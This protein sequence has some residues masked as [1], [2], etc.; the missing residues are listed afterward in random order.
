MQYSLFLLPLF[1]S[2][3]ILLAL[4]IHELILRRTP[5]SVPFSFVMIL[6]S[7]WALFYALELGSIDLPTKILSMKL[8]LLCNALLPVGMLVFGFQYSG[9][10]DWL[11]PERISLFLIEPFLA[12]VLAFANSGALFRYNYHVD[13]LHATPALLYSNGV[14]YPI[15]LLYLYGL[16]VAAIFLIAGSARGRQPLFKRQV[17]A[18][19]AAIALPVI[20]DVLFQL[21]IISWRSVN[22]TPMVLTAS[23]ILAAFALFRYRLHDVIPIAAI[24]VM[25]TLEDLM[26]VLDG[27]G[28]LIDFNARAQKAIGFDPRTTVGQ[29]VDRLPAP[30]ASALSRFIAS[31]SARDR[32]DVPGP[33]GER[34]YDLAVSPIRDYL[35]R[36]QG[37]LFLLHDVTERRL[38]EDEVALSRERLQ[39]AFDSASDGLWDWEVSTGRTYWSTRYYTMLGY[40]PGEIESSFQSWKSLVHPE[41]LER[42]LAG[43]ESLLSGREDA[44]SLEFRMRSRDGGWRWVLSRGK[45]VKRTAAGA[46]ERI[47]GTH[48]DIT[49]RRIMEDRLRDSEE[50]FRSFVEQTAEAII[51]IDEE[52]GIIEFNPAAERLA[53][54]ERDKALGMRIWD[55][56]GL[57]LSGEKRTES[58]IQA[59]K[60]RYQSALQAGKADFLN[61]TLEAVLQMPNGTIKHIQQYLFPIRTLSGWRIGSVSRDITEAKKAEEALARSREQLQQAQKMEAV[62]RLAGGIAHDFNNILTVISG[63]CDLVF[64]RLPED[65]PLREDMREIIKASARASSLTS[66]LLAFSRKQVLQPRVISVNE[67]VSNMGNMLRRVIGE[68]IELATFLDPEAGNF[69]ADPGQIEQVIMNLAVNS[70]DAMPRGGKLTIE[71]SNRLLDQSYTR[72]HPEVK[73]G[74]Y[75]RL[76]VSDTGHGM[77]A[78]TMSR[79]FEPFFTTKEKGKGT[80]LGLPMAYGIIKQSEGYISCYSEPGKGTIFVLYFPRTSV[81]PGSEL[82][83]EHANSEV[84]GNET[85]LLVEDE[86]A[87]LGFTTTVLRKNGYT[88]VEAASGPEALAEISDRA[89]GVSLLITDVVMPRMSG[90]ELVRKV[91]ELCRQLKVLYIS[92]YAENAIV[93][94]GILDEGIDFI[95]KPFSSRKLLEKVREILDRS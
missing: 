8:R 85:I 66:Q 95:Q 76:T 26:L 14:L 48:V 35:G 64:D 31:S 79:I 4:A 54:L 32:L 29:S 34:T 82:A 89:C 75:V 45:V 78:D 93:H 52:G 88:V 28:R 50:K 1:F 63:Y 40:K 58:H 18:A 84:A 62:G 73:P 55:L 91:Q 5:A 68:D 27:K 80:G 20:S 92:G 12:V 65:S 7:L 44:N 70:R 39:L 59:L 11:K 33:G 41:D 25:Q 2:S 47:V 56:M 22:P 23:G 43:I 69:R 57:Y 87:V 10:A 17:A 19:I 46:A 81:E 67:M 60:E 94:H 51:L 21:G 77:D 61:Q 15:H 71:T 72:E 53:A 86:D 90:R 42:T 30:W 37:S 24:N 83:S 6:C 9:R 13:L 3:A 38:A 16:S 49:G 36:S 74:E